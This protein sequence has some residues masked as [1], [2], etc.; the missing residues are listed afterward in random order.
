MTRID[1]RV[2]LYG[3]S[4]EEADLY[5]FDPRRLR[6]GATMGQ[7][8][9]PKQAETAQ[10]PTSEAG[11][12]SRDFPEKPRA[13]ETGRSDFES[14]CAGSIPAGAISLACLRRL[15]YEPGT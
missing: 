2:D 6:P 5:L 11:R 13:A 8:K 10:C 9:P 1:G 12:I 15:R 7:H 14:V 4:E 3:M